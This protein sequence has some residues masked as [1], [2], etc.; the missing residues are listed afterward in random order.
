[1]GEPLFAV[2]QRPLLPGWIACAPSGQQVRFALVQRQVDAPPAVRWVA[3]ADWSRPTEALRGLRRSHALHRHRLVALLERRQYQCLT[4]DAPADLPRTDWRDALRW[5]VKDSVDF[6]VD[7]A[8]VD[9]LTVPEG[10][11]YRAQ[12]QVIVVAAAEAAV[13]PLVELAADAGCGWQA[14]DIAETA[15]R[16]LCALVEPEGRAQALL[17]CQADHATLVITFHGELLQA[18]H[19][20]LTL[21]QVDAADD[22]VR[23]QAFDHAVLELQRTLDGFERAYGQAS[24]ARLLVAPM[25]GIERFCEHLRPAL[26]V[27]VEA[28]D[29]AAALDLSALPELAADPAALNPHLCA[30]GA[31]LRDD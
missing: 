8:A 18:R 28:F 11:S 4:L 22:G 31:A 24:L 16:N 2:R 15:L 5:Q 29:A 21:G 27:T 23:E 6:A 10:A 13:R 12:P 17:H 1:M 25:P 7:S 3:Q 26:Y 20:D 30:I 19:I 14:I 9:L